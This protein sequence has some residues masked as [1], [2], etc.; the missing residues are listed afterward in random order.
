M[1]THEHNNNNP[2]WGGSVRGERAN[3]TGL[4]LGWRVGSEGWLQIRAY[5]ARLLLRG[6]NAAGEEPLAAFRIVE[7]LHRG[8]HP[9]P[10]DESVA[11]IAGK[12]DPGQHE[13]LGVGPRLVLDLR[14][15]SII[16]WSTN[17]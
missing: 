7:C 13:R 11:V 17:M 5:T 2:D 6:R 15:L 12:I 16:F 3:F 14:F 4:V 9:A 8:R 10:A 1:K